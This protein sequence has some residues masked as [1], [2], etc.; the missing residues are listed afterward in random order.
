MCGLAYQGNFISFKM[1]LQE[2]ILR[3]NFHDSISLLCLPVFAG[4]VND[5]LWIELFL[6]RG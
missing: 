1:N 3:R 6:G 2:P 4:S 5:W